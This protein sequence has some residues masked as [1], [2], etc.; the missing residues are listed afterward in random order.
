VTEE[1]EVADLAPIPCPCGC[2]LAQ[3]SDEA[4]AA[5]R[6]YIRANPSAP[7][8]LQIEIHEANRDGDE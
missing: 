3:L 1:E 6:A 8:E 7:L 2:G 4:L 5:F